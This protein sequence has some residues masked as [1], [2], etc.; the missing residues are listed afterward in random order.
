LF[1]NANN[2]T[3]KNNYSKTSNEGAQFISRYGVEVDKLPHISI[4]DPRTGTMLLRTEGYI[5]QQVQRTFAA[6]LY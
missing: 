6:H 1:N 5:K 3:S 2:N 4:I